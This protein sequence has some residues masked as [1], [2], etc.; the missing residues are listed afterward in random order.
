ML[1]F[2]SLAFAELR[3]RRNSLR[4]RFERALAAFIT[5]VVLLPSVS[6]SDDIARFEELRFRCQARAQVASPLSEKPSQIPSLYLARLADALESLQASTAFCLPVTL[7]FFGF[8]RT[9]S[10]FRLASPAPA[11]TGR[12]PPRFAPLG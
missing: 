12:A 10:K 8:V 9:N 4:A 2:A 3:R 11:P 7:G 6:A 1:A 5:V